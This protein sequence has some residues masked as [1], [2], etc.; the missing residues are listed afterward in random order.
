MHFK[1]TQTYN[2]GQKL[3]V[4]LLLEKQFSTNT[5]KINNNY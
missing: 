2:M 4:Y 3:H 1:K 5:N